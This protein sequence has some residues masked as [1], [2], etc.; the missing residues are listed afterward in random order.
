M[1][2]GVKP[3]RLV[4]IYRI[5]EGFY[6]SYVEGQTVMKQTYYDY[7]RNFDEYLTKWQATL[8]EVF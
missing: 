2:W 8:P 5:F 1:F 7:S 4:S 3:G 6:Y